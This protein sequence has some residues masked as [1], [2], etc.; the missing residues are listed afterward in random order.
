MIRQSIENA[1]IVVLPPCNL[2]YY[3]VE[4][5]QVVGDSAFRS[6]DPNLSRTQAKRTGIDVKDGMDWWHD[7]GKYV[8]RYQE[9]NRLDN[10][11][12]KVVIDPESGMVLRYCDEPLTEH[13]RPEVG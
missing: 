5:I 1:S 8:Y 9:V 4:T 3:F 13:R 12:L 11:Y 10:R 6:R 2:T 7:G